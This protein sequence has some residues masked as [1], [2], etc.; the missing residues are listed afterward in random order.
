MTIQESK[1]AQ[2][3]ERGLQ[4]RAVQSKNQNR[5]SERKTVGLD[6]IVQTPVRIQ[7]HMIQRAQ[8]YTGDA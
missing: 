5:A 2:E 4:K 7:Q 8:Y 3:L 1:L 6:T